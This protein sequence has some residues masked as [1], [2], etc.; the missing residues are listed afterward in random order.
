M[1]KRD[2]GVLVKDNSC[3][4]GKVY[5][6][7]DEEKKV[8]NK[9]LHPYDCECNKNETDFFKKLQIIL[10]NHASWKAVESLPNNSNIRA[11]FKKILKKGDDLIKTINNAK[12]LII[13][14]LILTSDDLINNK[15]AMDFNIILNNYINEQNK[16][17]NNYLKINKKFNSKLGKYLSTC[18]IAYLKVSKL[19][20]KGRKSNIAR[21][22]TAYA[23]NDLINKNICEKYLNTAKKK[24]TEDI[25]SLCF[26]KLDDKINRFKIKTLLSI[27]KNQ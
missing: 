1:S 20:S 4:L 18:K 13:E 23:I 7:T 17:F 16:I 10:N 3:G 21:I 2:R 11:H 12:P 26:F 22:Q 6:Y 9:L 5:N 27:S 19:P 24:P 25:I 14:D 8:I 15:D